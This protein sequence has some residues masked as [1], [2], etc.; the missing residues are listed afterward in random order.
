MLRLYANALAVLFVPQDEDFGYITVEAM[1]SHKPVIVCKDS[2][3]PALLVNNGRTGFVVNPD[4]AEIAGAMGILAANRELAREMGEHAFHSAPSQS[5]DQ[6]VQRLIE[7]GSQPAA[8][9]SSDNHYT[10]QTSISLLVADNQVL[11]PPVGGGRIRIYELYRHLAQLDF[12][13]TYIGA[14]DWPGPA[15]R[16]QMLASNFREIVTPLTQPHFAR[17]RQYQRATGG[18]T[19]I[20]VTIPKLLKYSPRFRRMAKEHGRR[21]E[22]V[23]ISHPWVHPYV[24]RRPGQKLI[25]DAH[26]C[27][28]I[29]KRQILSDTAA[30]R[31]LVEEVREL[32]KNLCRTA[33]LIFACSDD[34]ADQFVNLYGVE[35][36]KI[37][38]VPNG[39]DVEEIQPA[40]P[41]DR[42][43][44]RQEL[45][46]PLDR[47][48]LIFIGSGYAPN[49]EAAAFLV[50]EVAPRLPNCSIVI[51]GSVRDSYR[52]S[53]P[54]PAPEN[55]IWLGIVEAD[56]RLS[57]LSCSGHRAE[58]H[59]LRLRHE[60]ED[61]RLLC[62]RASRRLDTRRRS[63]TGAFVRR[64]HRLP[65]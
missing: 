39:V 41:A 13:I 40:S 62:G 5:W 28:Y 55:V 59:V 17:D 49:T 14:Y 18:K 16:D 46:L 30:G 29:V 12:D 58:S 57:L 45:G 7:A 37:V 21:A 31:K 19:T 33:D 8:S 15:Y 26:N 38:L 56:R 54:S 36:D 51:A 3:E 44:A 53:H 4:P 64:L 61:A 27:E 9:A 52:A 48:V 20:D 47:P 24:P 63:R 25:Y 11:D 10:E 1:L 43:G 34:D 23:I 42:E 32:E 50:K 35:R 22:A 2:G 6:V 65:A 60:S